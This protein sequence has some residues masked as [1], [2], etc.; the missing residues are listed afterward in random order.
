M[1]CRKNKAV[2]AMS[3]GVDS[4]VSSLLL[5]E[6]G[7]EVVGLT[8]IMSDKSFKAV[9]EAKKVCKVL[10]IRHET[11][12]LRE[13]FKNLVIDYFERGYMS[14]LTPNPC[15]FC[16]RTI[17]W[18]KM[19]D[20]VFNELNAGLYATGHYAR[21]I[22]N[23]IYRAKYLKKDQSYMLF[24]L[25]KEDMSRTVFPLGSMSKPDVREI[26]EKNNLPVA[27]SKESQ[28]VCFIQP[29]ETTQSYLTKRFG[30]KPGEIV[31]YK[32]GKVL[33]EHRGVFNYT[34]GQRKGI[35]VSAPEP[36]YVISM[37]HGEN[38]IMAGYRDELLSSEFE[39]NNVNRQ[40]DFT[41]RVMVKIRYNSPAQEGYITPTGEKTAHVRLKEPKSAVTPGQA[42]V[43]YDLN[44]EY[45][46]GGGII[47]SAG[48]NF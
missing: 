12:D 17:K 13:S 3:G 25:T 39:V 45:L 34:I 4:S 35:R 5:L 19:A 48:G 38:K 1:N 28:D 37:N 23:R 33:G 10:G 29:P 20:F 15:V 32:T 16:N 14:G 24:N 30:E 26:A 42:A 8:G 31:G 22:N 18:G 41:G 27:Q 46:L 9:E 44:N 36:L 40:Q 11:L 21:I 6:Q 7:Y 47:E 2:V 43:F